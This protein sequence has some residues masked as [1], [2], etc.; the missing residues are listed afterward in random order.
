VPA[1][2][3][4]AYADALGR[5]FDK[6]VR[7]D[8]YSRATALIDRRF[9]FQQYG[10]DLLAFAGEPLRRVSVIVPNYNYASHIEARLRSVI[11]QTYPIYELIVL[12]D[13]SSDDSVARVMAF[14][15]DATVPHQTVVNE[16]NSGSVFRQWHKG[17]ELAR[18]DLVWIAEA[19]DLAHPDFL[20]STVAGFERGVVMSYCQSRQ[21]DEHG[22]VLSN[23]YLDYVAD[24]GARRWQTAYRTAGTEEIAQAL[25]L[26]NTIPNVSAVVFERQALKAVLDDHGEEIMSY[27]NAGD[28]VTYLRLLEA[29]DIV[30]TPEALN[31]HRRH[32][33]SV[34]IGN[35]N[36]RH[37]DEIVKVQRMTISR[38]GLGN[39]S[40]GRAADYARTVAKQFGLPEQAI[41]DFAQHES[42]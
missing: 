40:A 34:T 31:D 24:L 12:D 7:A 32:S 39:T 16:K 33:N 10:L 35:A 27:R 42:F 5:S 25:F 38:H 19:D 6:K 2:D 3:V 37:L 14:L 23:D 28:W 18:G 17:V 22:T 4:L 15:R 29:G 26:K 41:G 20:T 11:N 30:F 8:C 1:F 13:A 36:Q 21:I 9:A